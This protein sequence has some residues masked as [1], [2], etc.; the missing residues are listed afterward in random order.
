MQPVI[1]DSIDSIL[2]KF[3]ED[4]PQKDYGTPIGYI[5]AYSKSKLDSNGSVVNIMVYAES[6]PEHDIPLYIHGT[7]HGAN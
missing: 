4:A 2:D 1:M 3:S 7:Y 6:K 5:S